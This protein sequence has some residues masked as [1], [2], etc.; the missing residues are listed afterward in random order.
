MQLGQKAV[1]EGLLEPKK[2]KGMITGFKGFES[3][4]DNRKMGKFLF[5]RFFF[6][7]GQAIANFDLVNYI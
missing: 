5:P 3:S 1:L 4:W 2:V 7:P 6:H